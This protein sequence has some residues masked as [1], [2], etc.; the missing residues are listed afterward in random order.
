MTLATVTFSSTATKTKTGEKAGKAWSI[1][2]Q[3]AVIETPVMKNRCKISLS[4]GQAPYDVGAYTFD[5][6][7]ML[8]VSDFGSIQLGRDLA[9]APVAT[10]PSK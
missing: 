5:P 3:D 6:C 9:L 8:K 10:P 1:T 7:F 2:E 4:N